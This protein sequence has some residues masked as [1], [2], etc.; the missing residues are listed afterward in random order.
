MTRSQRVF[1]YGTLRRRGSHHYLLSRGRYLGQ[2]V[3]PAVYTMYDLGDYPAVIAGGRHRICGEVY[4][5][6]LHTLARLDEYEA[7][8]DEYYRYLITTPFGPSWMYFWR[9]PGI[10]TG[11]A[12]RAVSGGD[13][14]QYGNNGNQK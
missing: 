13:W 1:V 8:P 14:L 9:Q 5:I 2:Y 12:A 6:S 11:Y 4:R 7:C 10:V 3:T